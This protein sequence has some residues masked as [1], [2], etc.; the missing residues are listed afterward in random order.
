MQTGS[1]GLTDLELTA[2]G[3]GSAPLGNLFEP[4]SD[5]QARATVDAA[6]DAGIRYFDT[7][8]HYGL[9]L[10][11]R[12][13]GA[14][15]AGRPRSEYVLSTKVG[16]L[17]V[18]SGE[19]ASDLA[20]GGFD[21]RSPLRRQLDFSADGVRRSLEES[22]GRLGVDRVDIVYVHDPDSGPGYER[23][24]VAEAMPALCALRDEGVI[25]AVGV[26]MNQW[27]MP[28]RL[29]EST[30]LDLVL[31][32]GRYTLLEQKSLEGLLDLCAKQDVAVVV[33]APF[34]SGLLAHDEPP[35]DATWNYGP[36]PARMLARARALATACAAA[37]VRL[38]AAALQFPLAHRAVV[39]VLAGMRSPA[40]VAADAEMIR[41]PLPAT[42]WTS[43]VQ[44]GLLPP[45]APTPS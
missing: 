17:L 1:V 3:Y 15:L 23:Q 12:R 45:E 32:A 8:P 2:L 37:G 10:A 33:G 38:P 42:L 16:R 25:G 5:E 6:W 35:A 22:L 14:A 41:E 30:D 39:S 29:V 21:L 31:I 18:D 43:L 13:L 27:Q 26:G 11:E 28:A 4:V 34:N 19:E 24:V 44:L 20:E 40:E 9:G 7:A 36:A